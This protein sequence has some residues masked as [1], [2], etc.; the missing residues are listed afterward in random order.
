LQLTEEN[1]KLRSENETLTVS[2]NRANNM[3]KTQVNILKM[4]Q[5]KQV[6]HYACICVSMC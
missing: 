3:S 4:A 5:Q 2:L 1:K 6:S